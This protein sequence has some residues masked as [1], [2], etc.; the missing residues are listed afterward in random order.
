MVV[1]LL[2]YGAGNVRSVRNAIRKLGFAVKDVS[3]PEDI[4]QAEKLV[5]PG[6]G[7]FG[8]A[9]RRLHE[10][11]YVEPLREHLLAGKPFL[12]I[13]LGLQTLF[14][15]SEESPGVPGLGILRG[16]VQRFRDRTLSV[17]QI[18]WNGINIRKPSV[19]FQDYQEEKLYFV[20][21]YR[22]VCETANRD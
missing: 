10:A 14:E 3:C 5:F 11:G 18:G 2:D 16:H 1:T 15:G 17:P 7:S 4:R 8:S 9:M 22:A 20:H 12:G 6:V 19:L 21:S 13:C